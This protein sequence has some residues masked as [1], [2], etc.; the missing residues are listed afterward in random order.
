MAVTFTVSSLAAALRLGDSDEEVAEVTRILEYV[1]EAVT[2]VA[3]DAPDTVHTEAARRMAGYLFDMPESGKGEGYGNSLRNSGAGRILLPYRI[4]RAAA[5][6]GDLVAMAQGSVGTTGNPVVD[7]TYSGDRLTVT[8]GDGGTEE[9]TIAGGSGVDQT[10]RDSAQTAQARADSAFTTAEGAETTA[11]AAEGTADTTEEGLEHHIA[12]H[13]GAVVAGPPADNTV[14]RSKLSSA[15]RA[16]VDAHADT[17][18]LVAHEATPHAAGLTA[19]VITGLAE[20][21]PHSNVEIPGVHSGV[22]GKYSFGRLIQLVASSVGL[23]PRLAPSPAADKAG[24]TVIMN[25]GGDGYT[26]RN[27]PF[28]PQPVKP[29]ADE[30][31]AI[32]DGDRLGVLYLFDGG[33]RY[34]GTTYVSGG[35]GGGGG[36]ATF[37]APRLPLEFDLTSS[38]QEVFVVVASNFGAGKRYRITSTSFARG[39]GD[40][41]HTL[42]AQLYLGTDI[43]DT[44][45][46]AINPEGSSQGKWAGTLERIVIMPDPPVSISVSYSEGGFVR[47]QTQSS[48]IVM[49]IS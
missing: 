21:D 16:D 24:E 46:T 5:A 36:P 11:E 32:A 6:G 27:Q 39:I 37:E 2:Q 3:P 15:L 31:A 18:D 10:A 28:V 40:A 38:Y 1:T 19:S 26:T 22:L 12:Q 48:L 47:V 20:G 43:L 42:N 14:T 4:H 23:G 7:V 41:Y 33:I 13:P 17:A 35:G 34:N 9:F 25:A 49:E 29:V 8:Y 44:A 45:N 30:A